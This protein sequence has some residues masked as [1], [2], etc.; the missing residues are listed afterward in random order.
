[1]ATDFYLNIASIPGEA[2]TQNFAGQIKL[3]S[4]SWGGSQLSSVGGTGGSGTG[5]VD[6]SDFTFTKHLDKATPKLFNA[7]CSGQ[8]V[9]SAVLSA[10]K[11]GAGGGTGGVYLK[12]TFSEVFVTSLNTSASDDVPSETVTITYNKIKIEYSTQDKQGTLTQAGSVTY[13]LAAN[14]VS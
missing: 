1:M 12:I 7:M 9:D 2:T 6:L 14:T 8:H 11:A 3:L 4:F 13:D 10:T 5:K